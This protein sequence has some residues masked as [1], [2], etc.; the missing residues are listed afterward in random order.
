MIRV[1]TEKKVYDFPKGERF[2]TEGGFNNLCIGD[3]RQRP[4]G[5]FSEGSWVFG[6][7]YEE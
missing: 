7:V 5:L 3:G 6:G 1:E 4:I 2:I